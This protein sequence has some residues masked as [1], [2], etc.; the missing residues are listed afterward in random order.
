MVIVNCKILILVATL[1]YPK[2]IQSLAL[3]HFKAKNRKELRTRTF[4]MQVTGSLLTGSALDITLHG[5][6]DSEA[7]Q[8]RSGGGPLMARGNPR[9]FA[10]SRESWLIS[11]APFQ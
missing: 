2:S 10:K 9:P 4:R 3:D 7:I 1:I 6:T 11:F 5:K 8:A